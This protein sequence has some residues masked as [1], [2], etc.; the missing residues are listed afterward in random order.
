M[1]TLTS[2]RDYR[3][4]IAGLQ[5]SSDEEKKQVIRHLSR[6][7]LYFLLWY[8]LGRLDA[9]DEWILARCRD[10]QARP[11]GMLDLWARE[12]YKST[13]IT[14]AKTIQDI[15]RSHGTDPL[16][17]REITVDRKSVV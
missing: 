12:H 3:T 5:T 4:L 1:T 14:F 10:V 7:D 8:T 9:E 11:N 16:T 17:S 2:T 15:L 13:I 6:T